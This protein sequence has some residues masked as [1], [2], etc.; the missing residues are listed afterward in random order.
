MPITAFA[1]CGLGYT[2]LKIAPA[3]KSVDF[4]LRLQFLTLIFTKTQYS[5]VLLGR[6]QPSPAWVPHPFP[7]GRALLPPDDDTADVLLSA[8]ASRLSECRMKTPANRVVGAGPTCL[9]GRLCPV[10]A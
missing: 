2:E 4:V 1:E 7:R 5:G 3:W 9:N 6:R 8:F 10:D